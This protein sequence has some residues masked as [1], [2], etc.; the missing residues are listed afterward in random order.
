MPPRRDCRRNPY[1]ADAKVLVWKRI[2]R[3]ETN[4]LPNEYI[5]RLRLMHAVRLLL[6][7]NYKLERIA[8]ESGF[9][10]TSYLCSSFLRF[11]KMTPE[12]F[13]QKHR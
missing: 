13:R 6:R 5:H 9:H 11:F 7:Y 2:F 8:T 4:L 3:R 10:S 12:S 1:L